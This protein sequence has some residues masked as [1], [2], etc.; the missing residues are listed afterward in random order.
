MKGIGKIRGTPL[1]ASACLPWLARVLVDA[2]ADNG[3]PSVDDI[4]RFAS[5][6]RLAPLLWHRTA[7]PAWRERLPSRLRETWETAYVRQWIA[8]ESLLA[9]LDEIR[10]AFAARGEPLVL[11]KGPALALRFYGDIGERMYED[12]DLLVPRH[13]TTACLQW[14]ARDHDFVSPVRFHWIHRALTHAKV[15]RRGALEIDL[16]WALRRHPSFAIDD[17]LIWATRRSIVLPGRH[18]ATIDVLSDEH[19]LLLTLLGIFDDLSRAELPVKGMVDGFL[20]VHAMDATTDWHGFLERRRAEGLFAVVADVLA[21]LLELFEA[22]PLLP[23]VTAALDAEGLT[24]SRGAAIC[25]EPASRLRA[26][27]SY[28]LALY[29]I[30]R[31]I[32]AAYLLLTAPVLAVLMQLEER[33]ATHPR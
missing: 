4:E 15:V 14:L 18:D 11:L 33:R 5:A 16:H 26:L 17:E 1:E 21:M 10:L 13:S 30:P 23:A 29:R 2:P 7:A 6:H 3:V 8:N 24:K 28:R 32:A 20:I 22:R 25:L 19:A 9:S 12:I 31:P 27:W